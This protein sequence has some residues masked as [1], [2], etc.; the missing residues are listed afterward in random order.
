MRNEMKDEQKTNTGA[1]LEEKE[2]ARYLEQRWEV[3]KT[4][5]IIG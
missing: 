4:K 3:E 1:L 5:V 2:E